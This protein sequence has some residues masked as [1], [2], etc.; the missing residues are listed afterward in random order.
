MCGVHTAK[1][2]S[3]EKSLVRCSDKEKCCLHFA[4]LIF[5]REKSGSIICGHDNEN[6][7]N[8]PNSFP[9]FYE[10]VSRAKRERERVKLGKFSSDFAHWFHCQGRILA[11]SRFICFVLFLEANFCLWKN[12][13][14]QLGSGVTEQE[15]SI[16]LNKQIALFFYRQLF[17]SRTPHCDSRALHF[18]VGES[19]S[20]RG[21]SWIS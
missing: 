21:T 4:S 19:K 20:K 2:E 12:N 9:P 5:S 14:K 8:T 17:F 15:Y 10:L 3:A 13:K 11:Q 18:F 16:I 7:E 1:R 6:T